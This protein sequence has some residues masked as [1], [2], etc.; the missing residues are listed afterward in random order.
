MV[1]MKSAIENACKRGSGREKAGER[2]TA[3]EIMQ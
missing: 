3:R 2:R 1:F